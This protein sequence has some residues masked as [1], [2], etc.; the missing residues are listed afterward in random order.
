ML[1]RMSALSGRVP[2]PG[3][4]DTSPTSSLT[5]SGKA[6][7]GSVRIAG[8]ASEAEPSR[9]AIRYRPA[10]ELSMPLIVLLH[11]LRVPSG[12]H[13]QLVMVRLSGRPLV[14]TFS[15]PRAGRTTLV[16]S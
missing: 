6:R 10:F 5:S 1:G 3:L 7:N 15:W 12:V 11:V 4:P 16:S 2:E 13:D 8:N 9:S 14:Q